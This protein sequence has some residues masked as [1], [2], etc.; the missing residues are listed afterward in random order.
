MSGLLR[1]LTEGG[2]GELQAVLK[3]AGL[4]AEAW[5]VETPGRN[6]DEFPENRSILDRGQ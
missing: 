4:F 3:H 2:P 6:H 5:S 1:S